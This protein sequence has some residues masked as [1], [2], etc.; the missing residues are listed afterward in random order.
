M[1]RR[2]LPRNYKNE[3]KTPRL[4]LAITVVVEQ[5]GD[6]YYAFA[7]ALKGLRIYDDTEEQALRHVTDAISVYLA[8]LAKHGDPF[9]IGPN[10]TVQREVVLEIPPTASTRNV[11]VTWPTAQMSAIS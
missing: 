7:P 11:M 4:Q 1:L 6:G 2:L 10:L 5:D 3:R 8:S 9:P